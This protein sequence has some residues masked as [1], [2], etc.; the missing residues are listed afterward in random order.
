MSRLALQIDFS[1]RAAVTHG[2]AVQ[3]GENRRRMGPTA[4][5]ARSAKLT[6]FIHTFSVIE[7]SVKWGKGL[8]VVV[9]GDDVIGRGRCHEVDGKNLCDSQLL[10]SARICGEEHTNEMKFRLEMTVMTFSKIAT[11]TYYGLA[12][13]R[14]DTINSSKFVFRSLMN[15]SKTENEQFERTKN[16]STINITKSTRLHAITSS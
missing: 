5:C 12:V 4:S 7:W 8:H 13:V 6:A 3:H 15:S 10:C 11:V 14:V 1:H 2:I 9:D 16:L